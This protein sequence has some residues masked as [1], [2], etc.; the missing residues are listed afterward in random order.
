M[1]EL[2]SIATIRSTGLLRRDDPR[3]VEAWNLRGPSP[4]LVIC[5]HAGRAVP[6]NL[7][8]LGLPE[9]EFDRHIAWDIGAGALARR[10]GRDLSA[11]VIRQAYSRL[12]VDCN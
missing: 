1:A 11:G 9:H 8:R 5:D 6:R 12:V 3:P 10:L 2:I 7:G 4:W